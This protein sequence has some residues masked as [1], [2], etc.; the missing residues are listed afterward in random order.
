MRNPIVSA[1]LTVTFLMLSG[2]QALAVEA[3]RYTV[4]GGDLGQLRRQVRGEGGIIERELKY[5]R[6]FAVHLSDEAAKKLRGQAG[7]S[8]RIE[9]DP[10]AR[11]FGK[12]GSSTPIQPLQV[13]PWGIKAVKAPDAF[14]VSRGA[15][16]TVCVIDTGIQASHP[17]LLGNVV[18]GENF[19]VMKGSVNPAAWADDN[20]HGTH[21][22]GTLAALDNGIGVV[23]VAPASK[24]F[25]VKVLN[26]R[27]TGYVSDIA[28]G[29]RS[30]VANGAKVIN[31]SIGSSAGSA[32]LQDAIAY[33]KNAGV[34]SVAA[35]GNESGPVSYPAKYPEVIAVSAVDASMR[36]AYFSNT[37]S[38]VDFAAP[39]VSVLS[40][41][42]GSA[43]ATFSGTSMASPHV[44]GVAALMI[45][46]G[47]LGLSAD[48]IG[49]SPLQQGQGFVNALGTVLNR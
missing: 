49:L 9:L 48:S 6:G 46:S 19:V 10:E 43:Y 27:G 3:K 11:A 7:S 13:I 18:G 4:S 24:L 2:T 12:P 41:T 31:M 28:E 17:D 16:V 39:G 25:A 37:G 15:G 29:I 8:M 26:S 23:G 38:E 34:V 35:A 22:A 47:A 5:Y 30:C 32:L 42:Q 21:V 20:G 44:A 36:I 45:S 1:L 33:A 14:V 40:S